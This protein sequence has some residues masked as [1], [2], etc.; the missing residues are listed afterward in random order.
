MLTFALI[1]EVWLF[2]IISEAKPMVKLHSSIFYLGCWSRNP[3]NS[4]Q[5]M[6]NDGKIVLVDLNVTV[7]VVGAALQL[8]HAYGQLDI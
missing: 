6:I 4:I 2:E 8:L 5:S 3:C 7:K 1:M